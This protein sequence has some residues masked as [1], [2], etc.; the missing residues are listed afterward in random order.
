M[1][2]V[3][4]GITRTVFLVGRYAIKV[5]SLRSHERG[6]SGVLWS[7]VR[8]A[9]ANLSEREWSGSTGTCPVLWSLGGLINVYPRCEPVT[10]D[11]TE[12]E[13]N[14]IGLSNPTD[15][16]PHNVGLLNGRMV[17]IDYDMNWNDRPPC[18]HVGEAP[19]PHPVRVRRFRRASGQVEHR[20]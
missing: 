14:A 16:K 2:Q 8:G 9:S 18:A 4:R 10:W 3:R 13:Y 19:R 1:I 17:W 11:P 7:F 15:K 12:E 6:F 20:V 5:P